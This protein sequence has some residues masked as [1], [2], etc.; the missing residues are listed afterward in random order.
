M[1]DA[2]SSSRAGLAGDLAQPILA[3]I[4]AALVGFASTFTLVLAAPVHMGATSA[5]AA[6]GL[7]ALCIAMAGVGMVAVVRH[8][9]ASAALAAGTVEQL[10]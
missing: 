3:G 6:S 10:Q 5:E 4:L 7:F 9:H 8:D 1:S 2:S